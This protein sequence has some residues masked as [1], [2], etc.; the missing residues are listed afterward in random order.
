MQNLI[1]VE[2]KESWS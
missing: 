2:F 1:Y